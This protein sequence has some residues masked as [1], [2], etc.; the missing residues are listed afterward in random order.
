LERNND[1]DTLEVN[2][3]VRTYK[4]HFPPGY[5]QGD[6]L[7]PVIIGLHGTGGNGGQFERHYHFSEKAD[8][9]GLIAVYPNKMESDGHLGVRTWNAG[10]CC[11]FA[12]REQ[13]FLCD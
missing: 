13:R 4:V 9:E 1:W 3:L 5:H 12:V 10:D 6:T 2:G 8:E 7:F 11:D